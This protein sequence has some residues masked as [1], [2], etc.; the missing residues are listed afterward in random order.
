EN[1]SIGGLDYFAIS[2]LSANG[3]PLAIA[4]IGETLVILSGGFDLSAAAVISLTNVFLSAYMPDTLIGQVLFPVLALGIGGL[5]GSINGFFVGILRLPAIVVTLA[6]MFI[7]Q[8]VTL[9]IMSQPG[10]M[11]PSSFSRLLTGDAIPQLL[12]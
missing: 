10:G 8:G 2:S 11:I 1:L 12:P 6:M 5:V 7:I 3:A 4:A 9:L